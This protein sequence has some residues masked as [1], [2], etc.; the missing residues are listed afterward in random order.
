MTRAPAIRFSRILKARG[1]TL[2]EI[3]VAVAVFAIVAV[4]IY[5]RTGDVISQ[6]GKLEQHTMAVWVADNALAGLSL[7]RRAGSQPLALGRTTQSTRMANRDWQV[8]IK[9]AATGVPTFQRVDI[10]VRL[11][12]A[13]ANGPALAQL[14]GF[15]GTN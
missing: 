3:V 5:G 14:I 12:D 8:E 9:V 7:S 13:G 10:A 2:L 11:A 1:F 4:V 15:L 6:T